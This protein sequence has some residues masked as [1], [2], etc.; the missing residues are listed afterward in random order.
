MTK[1]LIVGSEED[2]ER[3]NMRMRARFDQARDEISDEGAFSPD[4]IALLRNAFLM[5]RRGVEET[6]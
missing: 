3:R 6:I 1:T 4:Q 2:R 5:M